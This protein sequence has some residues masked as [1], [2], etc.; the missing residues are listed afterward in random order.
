MNIALVLSGGTGSRLG[1]DIPKQY[2]RVNGFMVITY[3]IRPLLMSRHIDAIV[4]VAD[5]KW[6]GE[7]SKDLESENASLH[8]A[9]PGNNRQLSILSGMEKALKICGGEESSSAVNSANEYGSGYERSGNVIK[10]QAHTVFIHD[11]ARPLLKAGQIDDC[12]KALTGHD[13]VMP[14]LPMKDTVYKEL[15]GKVRPSHQ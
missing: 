4:V 1:G 8:F 10:G 15:C 13:G 3:A 14:V 5:E 12:Y 7:I 9:D 11:A 6:R 2:I